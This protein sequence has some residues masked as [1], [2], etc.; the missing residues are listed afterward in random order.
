[1]SDDALF[2]DYLKTEG[3]QA[4]D[5]S[6]LIGMYTLITTYTLSVKVYNIIC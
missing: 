5:C 4:G 3:L 2:M 6:K 1:M